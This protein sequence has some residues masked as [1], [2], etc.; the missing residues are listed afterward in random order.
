[1]SFSI[2]RSFNAI[3]LVCFLLWYISVPEKT[4]FESYFDFESIPCE[5]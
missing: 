1:M 3:Q 4:V 5:N 2:Y